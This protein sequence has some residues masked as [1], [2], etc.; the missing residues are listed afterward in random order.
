MFVLSEA[1]KKAASA[2]AITAATLADAE[3][4]MDQ[5]EEVTKEKERLVEEVHRLSDICFFASSLK[6]QLVFKFKSVCCLCDCF[7]QIEGCSSHT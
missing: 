6:T 2:E 4:V 5:V 3:A 7:K 1:M